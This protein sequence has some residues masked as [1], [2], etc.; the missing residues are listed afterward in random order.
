MIFLALQVECN[1]DFLGIYNGGTKASGN[2]VIK[3]CGSSLPDPIEFNGKELLLRF[4]SDFSVNYKGF[5][6]QF[7]T[8]GVVF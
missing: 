6:L 5:K 1:Y 2:Q 7:T 4:H 8:T 3:L